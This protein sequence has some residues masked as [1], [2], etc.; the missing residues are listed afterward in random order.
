MV[1]EMSH[2]Q[3]LLRLQWNVL[4]HMNE[5]ACRR[6]AK[7]DVNKLK[8]DLWCLLLAMRPQIHIAGRKILIMFFSPTES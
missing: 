7:N 5:N 1:G 6:Y 4:S 2:L 3:H 8:K